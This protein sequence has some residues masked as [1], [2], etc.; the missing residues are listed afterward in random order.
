MSRM[1]KK[2]VIFGGDTEKVSVDR[3]SWS[4]V[5]EAIQ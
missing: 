4:R 1:D 5:E 3:V 2:T